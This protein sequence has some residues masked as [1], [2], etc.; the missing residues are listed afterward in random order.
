MIYTI[1]C[2]VTCNIL[3]NIHLHSSFYISPWKLKIMIPILFTGRGK[4][5]T[6]HENM[7]WMIVCGR[8]FIKKI[9]YSLWVFKNVL[10]IDLKFISLMSMFLFATL[11]NDGFIQKIWHKKFFH[12]LYYIKREFFFY[13]NMK[14]TFLSI[15][16][17][18]TTIRPSQIKEYFLW[19][20]RAVILCNHDKNF[21]YKKYQQWKLPCC[22]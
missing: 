21:N 15:K 5:N 18:K 2:Y 4:N 6:V 16:C 3:L 17:I 20:Q 11:T 19:K 9:K 10:F 13:I 1:T 8:P 12:F 14:I 7:F 22:M